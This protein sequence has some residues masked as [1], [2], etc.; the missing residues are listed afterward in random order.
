MGLM[1]RFVPCVAGTDWFAQ[2]RDSKQTGKLEYRLMLAVAK[3]FQDRGLNAHVP[4]WHVA[5]V[6]LIA[7]SGKVLGGI[8]YPPG[9]DVAA[10]MRKALAAYPRLR[11]AERL[12]AKAPDPETDRIC[13]PEYHSAGPTELHPPVGGLTLR[14]VQRSRP[15]ETRL[16]NPDIEEQDSRLGIG[17]QLD[18]L[19]LLPDEAAGLVPSVRRV[20]ARQVVKGPALDRLVQT[21]LGVHVLI[22]S[23]WEPG[24]VKEA[25]LTAEVTAVRGTLVELRYEGRVWLRDP[26]YLDY[27]KREYTGDLLGKA[28]Y[29]T[30]GKRFTAFE[31]LALGTH[32]AGKHGPARFAV[33]FTL[34]GD[35]PSDQVPPYY[36]DRY[37]WARSP[38]AAIGVHRGKFVGK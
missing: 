27:G 26:E 28:T 19:W 3:E 7:P 22:G 17:F 34:A 23:A 29:D 14:V 24:H 8:T 33:A 12:L 21:G 9:G 11:K 15:R 31:L 35:S 5:G 30:R 2:A 36:L 16:L 10:E 20:G 13:F 1:G 32:V 38:D 6:F 4:D 18:H 37:Q 25:R